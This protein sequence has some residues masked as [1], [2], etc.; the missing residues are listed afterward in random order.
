MFKSIGP[1]LVYAGRMLAKA[2]GFTFVWVVSLGIGM[3][4]VIAIP[5]GARILKMPPPG[6]NTEGL[7]E[8]VMSPRGSRAASNEWSYPDF[9]DLRDAETGMAIIGWTDVV[10]SEVT[11]QTQEK[12]RRRRRRG[13]CR[14][15]TSGRSAWRWRGDR[16]S[17]RR[18]MTRQRRSPA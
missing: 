8:L 14:P 5:H 1:D 10:E 2:R 12:R 17:T 16:D 7:V 4:P 13:S 18:R 9:L 3:A 15:T 11:V 6:V